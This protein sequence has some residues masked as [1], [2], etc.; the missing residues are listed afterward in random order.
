MSSRRPAGHRHH[1][2][3]GASVND[4]VDLERDAATRGALAA[5]QPA[6]TVVGDAVAAG[7]VPSAAPTEPLETRL[8][9]PVESGTAVGP[10]VLQLDENWVQ[11][12]IV[13]GTEMSGPEFGAT[14]DRQIF[15]G[16]MPGR[17]N[18]LKDR[19]TPA[20]SPS[21]SGSR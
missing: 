19:Y 1:D 13:V 18:H 2:R 14:A 4:D 21:R 7:G 3:R 15:G 12:Q 17:W 20:I 5:G 9:E 6:D 10:G 8:P 11:F 16:P